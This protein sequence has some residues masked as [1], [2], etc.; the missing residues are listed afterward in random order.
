[1]ELEVLELAAFYCTLDGVVSVDVFVLNT[2]LAVLETDYER[3]AFESHVAEV[4]LHDSL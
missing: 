2:K 4:A 3:V 1:L